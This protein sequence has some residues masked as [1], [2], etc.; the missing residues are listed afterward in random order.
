MLTL[1]TSRSAAKARAALCL[2]A[3]VMNGKSQQ[4]HS[5][6]ITSQREELMG[7]VKVQ[8]T[9]EISNYQGNTLKRQTVLHRISQ[10]NMIVRS[11]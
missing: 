8:R 3:P 2:C 6:V 5:P 1:C 9:A 7:N 10:N 4:C 11:E